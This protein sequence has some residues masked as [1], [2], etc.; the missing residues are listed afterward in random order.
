LVLISPKPLGMSRP[1]DAVAWNYR[2][3]MIFIGPR[4][5]NQAT[6]D[7]TKDELTDE[8]RRQEPA[9]S[10][11]DAALTGQLIVLLRWLSN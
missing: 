6:D 4:A 9:G 7:R 1:S 10:R 5:K 11:L 2:K 3:R 8:E